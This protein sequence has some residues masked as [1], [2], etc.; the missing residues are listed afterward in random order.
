MLRKVL[1]GCGGLAV[2]S[3][4]LLVI[5]LLLVP[6]E[7]SE[8]AGS[9]N[10]PGS[11]ETFTDENYGELFAEPGAYEGAAVEV[12]GQL[13]GP[14]ETEGDGV[15]FQIWADPQNV[16]WNTVVYASS[17]AIPEGLSSDDYVRVQGVADGVFEGENAFG[18]TID[19]PI[20]EAD[21]V[22]ATSAVEAIDPALQTVEVNETESDQGF[23]ITLERIEFGEESTRAYITVSNATNE[24]A[25]FYTFDARILQGSRQVD[26]FDDAFEYDLEEPQSE[27]S[28]GV[29]SEGAVV[30]GPV[31]P[32]QPF[33]MEFE[34][35][36][37]NFDI[38]SN[39]ISFD[40]AP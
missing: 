35:F 34:W 22:E 5:A 16:E 1:I 20:I 14:P 30:F 6:A 28:P 23:A 26:V 8:Q 18:A 31:N 25:S 19:A 15:A 21:S 32:D 9:G 12:T 38:T 10:G 4:L 37:D 7:D 40:V 13:L 3:F 24:P 27:L 33:T 2:I 36:S 17:D 29:E 11:G 39:P